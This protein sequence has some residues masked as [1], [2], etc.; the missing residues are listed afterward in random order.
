MA[1]QRRWR[2]ERAR[3]ASASEHRSLR[4]VCGG[5]SAVR[6][7]ALGDSLTYGLGD[8]MPDGRWRGWAALLAESLAPPDQLQFYNLAELGSMSHTLVDSQLSRALDLNPTIAAVIVGSNDTLRSSFDVLRTARA[9]DTAVGRL[10]SAGAQVLT[11]RLPDPGRMFG[12]P[13]SLARPLARR[14]TA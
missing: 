14:I 9:L 4:A 12:L 13:A 8:R 11:S 5:M 7:V 3:G 2:D 10:R 6:F 1:R